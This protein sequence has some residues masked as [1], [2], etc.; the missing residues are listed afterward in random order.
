MKSYKMFKT[1][2][3]MG[4]IKRKQRTSAMNKQQLQTWQILIQIYKN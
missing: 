3:K 2:G 4:K 1:K